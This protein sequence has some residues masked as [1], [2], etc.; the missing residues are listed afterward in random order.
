[1]A[2][3]QVRKEAATVFSAWLCN[4]QQALQRLPT[5]GVQRIVARPTDDIMLLNQAHT[6]TYPVAL[7]DECRK[8]R[9]RPARGRRV[10]YAAKGLRPL[11]ASC[12]PLT[13]AVTSERGSAR[14]P[15]VSLWLRS[16]RCRRYC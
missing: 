15:R 16:V 13:S 3:S 11:R 8:E 9:K 1:M 7:K 5:D 4:G 6:R 2:K 10:P 12:E 14:A